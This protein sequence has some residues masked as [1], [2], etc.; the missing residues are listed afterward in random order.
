MITQL[1]RQVS[2]GKYNARFNP[3]ARVPT[4][5]NATRAHR[6][7]HTRTQSPYTHT[8]HSFQRRLGP[9]CCTKAKTRLSRAPL[10][11][12]PAEVPLISWCPGVMSLFGL[13][14]TD[15]T[16]KHQYLSHCSPSSMRAMHDCTRA[17]QLGRHTERTAT[18]CNTR[19]HA[20]Q[21]TAAW[22]YTTR[23]C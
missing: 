19:T 18:Y 17:C 9:T 4:C 5:M 23:A 22:I 8:R 13:Q 12:R 10:A 6:K 16:D 21:A 20:W 3:H 1:Q 15:Q 14:L 11:M 2:Q 7:M